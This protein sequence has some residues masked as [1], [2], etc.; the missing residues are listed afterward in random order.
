FSIDISF[1]VL[2]MVI[3]GGLCS[4]FGSYMG[5]AFLVLFPVF[6]KIVFVDTFGWPTDIAAHVQIML[7]GTLIIFFLIK[8]PHGMAAL[9]R[10][11]KE[12][13]RLWPFPH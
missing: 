9:W 6:I 4:I 11:L 5:A 8:E 12:K 2:F 7:I 1:E 10:T 3:L 13:L